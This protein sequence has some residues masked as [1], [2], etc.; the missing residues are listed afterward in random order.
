M[1]RGGQQHVVRDREIM[2]Y[3]AA[4]YEEVPDGVGVGDTPIVVEDRTGGVDDTPGEEQPDRARGHCLYDRPGR[5]D[6]QPSHEYVNR[7]R[8]RV[9]TPRKENLEDDTGYGE[10]PD[11]TEECPS[12]AAAQT[13]QGERRVA[14]GN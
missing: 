5:D 2:K 10:A 13:Y 12:P 4:D 1:S 8:E 14:R 3:A 11:Q 7:G 9:Q 6:G